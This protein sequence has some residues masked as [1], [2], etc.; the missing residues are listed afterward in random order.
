MKGD[1]MKATA[2]LEKQH[3]KVESIF[4]KLG[5]GR[6]EAAPLLV[7]LAN[8][9]TA[10]MAIEQEI[11]Y[12][13]AREAD[14]DMVLESFE[15]HSIAEL[16]LRRLLA[17]DPDDKAFQAR[18]T[19]LKELIEH[20]VSEEEDDLFPTVEKALGAER[21]E[22]LGK[23]MKLAFDTAV[24]RGF[25]AALPKGSQTAADAAEKRALAAGG[26]SR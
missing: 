16:T 21:L 18:V 8:D 13:A 2:L 12:P 25:E 6:S 23:R 24:E 15:E 3:R 7:E 4:K 9:L 22:S 17:T 14:E 20:H 5:G 10:H 11:F 19:V 1:T 26:E